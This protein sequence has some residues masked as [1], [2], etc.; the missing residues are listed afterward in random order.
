MI[1]SCF[2]HFIVPITIK[3]TLTTDIDIYIP[4]AYDFKFDYQIAD[5]SR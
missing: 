5:N 2:Q 4:A 1:R 3:H